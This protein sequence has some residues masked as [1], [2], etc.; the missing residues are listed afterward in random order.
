M[1]IIL[2]GAPTLG[3]PLRGSSGHSGFHTGRVVTAWVHAFQVQPRQLPNQLVVGDDFPDDVTWMGVREV[4]KSGKMAS[5]CHHPS[6]DLE[7]T[8]NRN[9]TDCTTLRSL[10]ISDLGFLPNKR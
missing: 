3:V 6:K 8:E 5:G 9:G 10:L 7:T 1:A 4:L 2:G